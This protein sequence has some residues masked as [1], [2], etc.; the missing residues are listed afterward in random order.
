MLSESAFLLVVM[1]TG[2]G[3]TLQHS[4]RNAESFLIKQCAFRLVPPDGE[5]LVDVFWCDIRQLCG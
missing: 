3:E 2:I 4:L 1:A 5:L